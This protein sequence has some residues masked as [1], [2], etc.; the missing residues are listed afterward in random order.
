MIQAF[1]FEKI[2]IDGKEFTTDVM[3]YP[4]GE[5]KKW[6]RKAEHDLQASDIKRIIKQDPKLVILGLGTV[7]NLNVRPKVYE[8]LKEAGIEVLAYKTD[9]AVETYKELREDEGTA[10]LL[11]LGD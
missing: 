5:I 10:A 6:K 1:E 4:N 3:I 7:G 9:K 11:H 8:E 2:V